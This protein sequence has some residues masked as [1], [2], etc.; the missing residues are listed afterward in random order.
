MSLL[1]KVAHIQCVFFLAMKAQQ[2]LIFL[3]Y[4]VRGEGP[5]IY[6]E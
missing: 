4:P 5:F 3:H 2:A 1:L 6:G